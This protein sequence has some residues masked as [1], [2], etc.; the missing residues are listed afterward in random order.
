MSVSVMFNKYSSNQNIQFG[1]FAL[2]KTTN[3]FNERIP[4]ID[5]DG[6][7]N[8]FSYKSA[9]DTRNV[10]AQCI[11][12][13][14]ILLNLHFKCNAPNRRQKSNASS[15]MGRKLASK[16]LIGQGENYNPG[17]SQ[18]KASQMVYGKVRVLP[19][20]TVSRRAFA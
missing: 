15:W 9:S 6:L 13:R 12:L 18:F 16:Q 19:K 14:L 7:E 10:S 17:N 5:I 3:T 20:T 11:T 1:T 8:E 2:R 4:E